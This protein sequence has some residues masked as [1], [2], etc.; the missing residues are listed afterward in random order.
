MLAVGVFL[1]VLY[2][3]IQAGLPSDIDVKSTVARALQGLYTLGL[4]LLIAGL[5]LLAVSTRCPQISVDGGDDIIL[6]VTTLLGIVILVLSA[7]L[8]NKLSGQAKSWSV[9]SLVIS[10]MMVVFCGGML[11]SKISEKYKLLKP[12]VGFGYCHA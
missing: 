9:M 1:I 8:V 7:I 12:S 3:Q 4:I 5:T 10:I 2:S 6:V 11:G